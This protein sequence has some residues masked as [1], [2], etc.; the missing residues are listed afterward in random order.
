MLG[1]TLVTGVAALTFGATA[2]H[3]QGA[4]EGTGVTEA[5]IDRACARIPNIQ[6]RLDNAVERITG[7]ADVR[8]SL[9]WLD[10]RIEAATE[11]GRTELA[12]ALTNRREVREATLDVIELRRA[13]LEEFAALCDD[14]S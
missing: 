5:R 6:A 7:E 3:A 9:R 2:V 4:T 11:A 13:N 1:A 8:G 12:T 10:A 14:R